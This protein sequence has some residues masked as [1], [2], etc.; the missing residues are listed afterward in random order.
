MKTDS[1]KVAPGIFLEEAAEAAKLLKLLSNHCRLLVLCHLAACGELGVGE[2]VER[3]GI[4]QSA[5]SQH[6]AKLRGERLVAARKDAQNVYYRIRDPR[7]ERLLTLLHEM[8]C[9]DLGQQPPSKLA[10]VWNE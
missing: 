10:G 9:P 4:S 3:V 7:A 1:S 6:L 8:F 5:L 2:L